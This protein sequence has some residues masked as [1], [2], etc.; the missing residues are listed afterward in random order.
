MTA[1]Y[2]LQPRCPSGWQ[3]PSF[4]C[5]CQH[6]CSLRDAAQLRLLNLPQFI[7]LFFCGC[8]QFSSFAVSPPL[9]TAMAAVLRTRALPSLGAR[10]RHMES[11]LCPSRLLSLRLWANL[12][13]C[14]LVGNQRLSKSKRGHCRLGCRRI[15]STSRLCVAALRRI[16]VALREMRMVRVESSSLSGSSHANRT[17]A[18]GG[19]VFWSVLF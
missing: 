4:C 10:T 11:V 5:S 12:S 13:H 9:Y 14:S 19:L 8:F 6:L 18:G 17:P 16:V 7:G 3:A 2:G 15:F 1:A